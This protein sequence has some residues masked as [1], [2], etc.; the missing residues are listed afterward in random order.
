MSVSIEKKNVHVVLNL[1]FYLEKKILKFNWPGFVC[2]IENS[3][4]KNITQSF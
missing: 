3:S 2:F 4:V 1:K